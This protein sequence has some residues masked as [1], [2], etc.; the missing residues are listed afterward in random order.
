[1]SSNQT[2]FLELN[3]L[4]K[5]ISDLRVGIKFFCVKPSFPIMMGCWQKT[6]SFECLAN[7]GLYMDFCLDG[8]VSSSVPSKH[9]D[10]MWW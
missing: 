2:R 10:V 3:L 1:M 5:I 9:F 6:V 8:S 4:H 7:S